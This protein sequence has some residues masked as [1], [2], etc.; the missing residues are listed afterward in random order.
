MTKV[1][2]FCP[3]CYCVYDNDPIT[4]D[5]KPHQTKDDN[6]FNTANLEACKDCECDE[7]YLYVDEVNV[8]DVLYL[9][10]SKGYSF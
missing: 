5:I 1:Q 8:L 9:I 6:V 2:T 7:D 10:A 4:F 3:G